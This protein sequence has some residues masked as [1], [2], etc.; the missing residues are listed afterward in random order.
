LGVDGQ[1][2]GF[3]LI[4]VIA[5]WMARFTKKHFTAFSIG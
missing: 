1:S 5:I 2:A 3:P 4:I